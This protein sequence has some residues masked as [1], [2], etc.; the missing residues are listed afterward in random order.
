MGRRARAGARPRDRPGRPPRRGQQGGAGPACVTQ[1]GRQA[2]RRVARRGAGD[3]RHL[4]LLH[5]RGPAP[6]R[7]DR[8]VGDARQAAVHVPHAGRRGGDHHR[9]QLPRRRAGLVPRAGHPVRQRRRLEA[10]RVLAG[11]RRRAGAAL[12]RRRR[13]RRRCSTSCRPRERR[14]SP[15]SSRRSR[16]GLVDKVGF[17]GSSR[18]RLED[19]RAVRPP[20]PVAVP[21]ARRQE[22]DGRDGRRGHRPRGR[23]RA[24]RRLRHRRPALHVARHG[25][26][27]RVGPRRVRA[28]SSTRGCARRRSATRRATCS[29][30]R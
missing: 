10:G 20:R 9:G 23:G 17:T 30:A 6:V 14:R 1:R 21:G 4:R 28:A 27:A 26:R 29:T 24:V 16:S 5:R 18:G 11:A 12:P 2:L 15:G 7:P 25:D 8:P 19:R 13:A 3:H 22:P